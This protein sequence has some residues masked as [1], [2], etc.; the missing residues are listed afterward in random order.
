MDSPVRQLFVSPTKMLTSMGKNSYSQSSGDCNNI[1]I[2]R[3]CQH[4]PVSKKG[5]QKI[6]KT[7]RGN[8]F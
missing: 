7:D 6:K 1:F 5:T 8:V 3:L 2:M 4:T